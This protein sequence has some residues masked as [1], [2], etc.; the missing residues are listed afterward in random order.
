MAL[1]A[2]RKTVVGMV[3][4]S[5]FWQVAIGLA[6]GVPAAL[7]AARL[8]ADQL[9]GVK[10]GDPM[11][12]GAAVLFLALATLVAAAIPARRAANLNPVDALRA[13]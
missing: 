13:E 7:G 5:A 12:L 6:L 4:R 1:G 2:N 8:I 3:L 9:Y 11:T 10:P